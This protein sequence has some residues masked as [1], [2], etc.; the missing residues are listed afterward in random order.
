MKKTFFKKEVLK[1]VV[2]IGLLLIV[3]FGLLVL[4]LRKDMKVMVDKVCRTY[5]ETK[6]YTDCYTVCK[7]QYINKFSP[8]EYKVIVTGCAGNY[9]Y[10][11]NW[12]NDF[13]DWLFRR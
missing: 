10:G 7:N 6:N 8:S 9:T 4:A 12:L 13:L 2:V 11:G 3:Y 5:C 1:I